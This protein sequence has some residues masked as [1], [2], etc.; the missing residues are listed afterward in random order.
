LLSAYK[1]L[2]FE[3]TIGVTPAARAFAHDEY[4]TA[5]LTFGATLGFAVAVGAVVG[6]VEAAVVGATVGVGDA[7]V[8]GVI[9]AVIA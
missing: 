2:F 9:P 1:V 3:R 4:F 5:F 8:I 7:R 6:S